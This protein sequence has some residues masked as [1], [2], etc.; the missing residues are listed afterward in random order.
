M[1][2]LVRIQGPDAPSDGEREG[3]RRFD[4]ALPR[5]LIGPGT[6]EFLRVVK[7]CGDGNFPLTEGAFLIGSIRVDSHH[8]NWPLLFCLPGSLT[9]GWRRSKKN[10]FSFPL[11][12]FNKIL[13]IPQI[14]PPPV[15]PRNRNYWIV[16]QSNL[17]IS[18][19][20]VIDV[21]VPFASKLAV[22]CARL[23]TDYPLHSPTPVVLWGITTPQHILGILAYSC[24]KE[25]GCDGS[26]TAIKYTRK[27]A[28]VVRKKL[29]IYARSYQLH[30]RVRTLSGRHR[31]LH[32]TFERIKLLYVQTFD[33]IWYC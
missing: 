15:F 14:K 32:N 8:W 31:S 2:V 11:K 7:V 3:V 16:Q 25:M 13:W 21:L 28:G 20:D 10:F 27:K 17:Y 23:S 19:G 12:T 1:S 33:T 30:Q 29:S 5:G 18:A 4:V 26:E 6:Q 24:T 22:S 9:F